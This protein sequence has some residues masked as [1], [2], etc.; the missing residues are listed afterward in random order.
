MVD[1]WLVY[2]SG[3]IIPVWNSDLHNPHLGTFEVIPQAWS[4]S[5]ELMFYALAP[6]LVRRH[7][8]VLVALIVAAYVLR[9]VAA[10][11]GFSGSCFAFRFFPF[12]LGL[13]LARVFS[14]PL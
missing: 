12:E 6:F 13:F 7:W 1:V 4:V 5:L 8:L 10:A 9:S 14:H 11:Y 2:Q 3:A